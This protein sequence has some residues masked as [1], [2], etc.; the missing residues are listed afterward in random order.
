V[1]VE[2]SL[3]ERHLNPRVIACTLFFAISAGLQITSTAAESPGLIERGRVLAEVRCGRCHAVGPTGESPHRITPPFRTF[4]KDFPIPMLAEAAATGVLAGH[5]E[6]PMFE[7]SVE[8]LTALLAYIDSLSPD[9]P[10]YLGSY[11]SHR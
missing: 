4:Q 8:E 7:F 9:K 3:G 6:M 11:R 1:L 2:D 5:E 10:S